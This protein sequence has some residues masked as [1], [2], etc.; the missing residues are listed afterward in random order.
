M[1]TCRPGGAVRVKLGVDAELRTTLILGQAAEQAQ[2][3]GSPT[4][5]VDGRDVVPGSDPATEYTL[6]GAST[7]S[8]TASPAS[9]RSAGSAKRCCAWPT[10]VERPPA[11][12]RPKPSAVSC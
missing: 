9:P 10:A 1:G 8:N 12:L 6:A 2:F 4:V 11:T 7:G 3:P 5:R